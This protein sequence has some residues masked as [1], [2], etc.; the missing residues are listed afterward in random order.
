M[1]KTLEMSDVILLIGIYFVIFIAGLLRSVETN[2]TCETEC[3][4]VNSY[5]AENPCAGI[6]KYLKNSQQ[7][8]YELEEPQEIVELETINEPEFNLEEVS[9]I[10]W[11]TMAEAEGECEYGKRLVIDT[12]LNRVDSEH[13]PNTINEVIYQK[14]QFSS[15]WNGRADRVSSNEYVCNLVKEEMISRTNNEV[16][17]FTAGDYGIY[18]TPMFSVENHYFSSQE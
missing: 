4:I 10:A 3:I 14:N 18:G 12:I 2:N 9:L 16:M 5:K 1:N 6:V 15:V 13:F 17:F 7:L 11:I 8:L